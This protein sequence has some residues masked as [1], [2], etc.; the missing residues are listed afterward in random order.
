MTELYPFTFQPILKERIWGGRLL[1]TDYQ[2]PLPPRDPIGESWEIT[3]RTEGVSVIEN[4]PLAGRDL[5]W[6]VENHAAALLGQSHP[7]SGRFPLLVK[8]IDAREK[9]SLQVHPSPESA[10]QFGGELKTELWY[11]AKAKPGALLYAG[12]KRGATRQEFESAIRDGTVANCFHRLPVRAGDALFLPSGRMHAI[13]EGIV[14]FEI[15]QN[16]DTTYRVFDWN[17]VDAKGRP[18]ELHIP[19]SLLSI[20]FTDFEPALVSPE[21]TGERVRSRLL[22]ASPP[23]E[24]REW[25]MEPRNGTTLNFESALVLAVMD[26]HIELKSGNTTLTRRSGQF[27]LVPA[28]CGTA[29]ITTSEGASLLTS[30][31]A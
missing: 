14:I 20:D 26:G 2:K 15:Q 1:E 9:L 27:C 17:R 6:L 30:T 12:L 4:G 7:S 24:T 10:Q 16:S 31:A 29:T 19:Q 25:Q 28:S 5:R 8:I 21:F 18:R 22:A 23:F 11:V 3:D 13:G